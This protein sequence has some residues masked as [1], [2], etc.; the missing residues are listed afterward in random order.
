MK[1]HE[2]G[3]QEWWWWWWAVSSREVELETEDVRTL[4]R[5]GWTLYPA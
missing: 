4:Y 2:R 1:D 5:K 3:G